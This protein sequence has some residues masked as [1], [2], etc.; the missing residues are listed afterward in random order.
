MR[1][2]VLFALSLVLLQTTTL[3]QIPGGGAGGNRGGQQ[4]NGRFYGKILDS[5]LNKGIDAASVQLIQNKLD[6]ATKK[7]KDV[8]IA[9]ML[10]TGNG[11][12]SLE[13]IPL[14][15]QYKLQVT[16]IGY[17]TYEQTVK[18]DI[19]MPDRNAMSS[20][21]MSSLLNMADK[22]LGNIKLMV[23]AQLLSNVT[24]TADKPLMQ[25]GIDRKIFNVE[26][27]I[28]SAG[29][30]AVDVMRNIPSLAVDLDGNVTLR[31]APP[32]IFIDGRPTTMQLDQIPAD[33]IESVEMITNPSAKFDAS[34]GTS[35]ILNIVLKKN[36]KVGYNGSVRVNVDSRGMV[37][38]GGDINIRQNKINFF[39]SLNYFPRKSIGNGWTDRNT[40]V[41]N[42]PSLLEQVDRN[43][44]RG[45]MAFAR[46]GF[47]Y[48]I[49]N[50]NTFSLSGS[51][52]GGKFKSWN[53]SD[54]YTTFYSSPVSS[55]FG[56]RNS[57]SVGD[58]RFKGLQAGYKH[59]FP[60]PGRELTAD[61]NF[62]RRDNMNDNTITTNYSANKGAAVDS[63]YSQRQ[64]GDGYGSNL[65]IQTDFVNPLSD[66]SKLEM[67]LRVAYNDN[68]SVNE[69]YQLDPGTGIYNLN[70]LL[71]SDFNSRST[72]L[73]AYTTYT[74]SIKNFGYQLGLRAE[75]STFDGEVP[76]KLSSFDIDFPLSFF[77][78]VFLSQKMKN[79]QEMQLNY[80]R[81]INRPGFYQLFPFID[82]SDTLNLS[83]G[84]PGLEPEFTNSIEVS[85]QKLFKNRDNFLA[86]VYFKNTNGLITRNQV[87]ENNPVTGKEQLVNTFVNA[88]S[89]YITG[90]EMTFKTKIYKWWDMT[91]NLNLFTS[92]I[93]IDDPTIPEQEQFFS[94]FGK[95][96]NTFKLAK[97]LNL[98]VSGEYQ[99]KTILPP[100]GGG[101]RFG[102]GGM[103]GQSSSTAQGFIRS[104]YFVDAGL[105][106]DFLKNNMASISLNVNDVFRT[107][108]SYIYSE[109]AFFTQDVFRRRDPQVFRLNF[110]WRFGKFDPNLFKRKN[111]KGER[112]GMQN[113]SEGIGM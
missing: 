100:G 7:R 91:T 45:R 26:K 101:N 34:G 38:A 58:F 6:T 19:K 27:S 42:P 82:Y 56:E 32:Q 5:Q 94:Y 83:R 44:N 18:F 75:S 87:L 107:R 17:K 60:K 73:A 103:F 12:F 76:S 77:P 105:R 92:K 30:T 71:S 72:I 2:I 113:M 102:G 41:G 20:G 33:A 36:K 35:G 31:N 11:D 50:R 63:S 24:V 22:D 21:D 64:N 16:A 97:N 111:L 4:M 74:S 66:K 85:Y 54:L 110:N 40:L 8:V 84:N 23:D 96:N 47:D 90:L 9:G 62:N 65:V 14:F 13:N 67:G 109:S 43:T 79:D 52:G 28:T 3:A 51:M 15:G 81:R 95:L 49:D 86:S 88:N 29:G 106:F 112:E 57:Y 70:S 25:L 69:I 78:S 93:N 37:G 39:S 55:L 1:R 104:N 80:S 59:N 53:Y 68:F 46:A 48:F 61:V 98:Q 108:R 89:S 99:S 10:T